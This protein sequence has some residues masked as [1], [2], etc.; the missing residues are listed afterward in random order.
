MVELIDVLRAKSKKDEHYLLKEHIKDT[1]ERAVQIW[2][3]VNKNRERIEYEMLKSEDTFKNLAK[4]LFL[5]DLGKIDYGFQKKVFDPEERKDENEEWQIIKE[6]FTPSEKKYPVD[7]GIRDHEIL[8]VIHTV[9]FKG[10]EEWDKKI[11]TAILLH[12]YNKFFMEREQHITR[13]LD[14]Y[15]QIAG[16][17]YPNYL[18]LMIEK[19]EKFRKIYEDLIEYITQE[20][21]G[22]ENAKFILDAL[23]ELKIDMGKLEELK[24]R[25]ENGVGVS[26]ILPLYEL[27]DKNEKD[28]L[29]FF[30]FLGLLRRC[31]YSAS[32]GPE[33]SAE[34]PYSIMEE[35]MADLPEK[36]KNKLKLD[37]MWQEEIIENYKDKE[38]IILIAPTGSGKTEFALLWA[39][40]KGKKLLYTLPLRV[41]LNDLFLR[42][43]GEDGYFKKEYVDLLHSTAFIEYLKGESRGEDISIGAKLKEI[44]LFASPILLTTPDQ[45]FLASLKYYGFDK[46]LSLYPS[47]TVVVD[48]IQAYDPEMA[49]I[50][51]KTL[52]MIKEVKGN[53]LIITATFPPYFEKFLVSGE[54]IKLEKVDLQSE[55]S[56]I[57][58]PIKNYDLRRHRV[59]IMDG[60]FVV[61]RK[62]ENK[63]EYVIVKEKLKEIIEKEHPNQNVLIIV[64]NVLKAIEVFR[65]LES[66]YAH[67]KL[68]HSRLMEKE[69]ESRIHEIKDFLNKKRKG[70]IPE[71]ERIIVVS[72][73]I[74]EASVDFDFDVLITEISPIDSQIQRWGRVHRNKNEGEN[75]DGKTPNI[76]IFSSID[77]GTKAIYHPKEVLERTLEVLQ[78]EVN[79]ESVLSYEEERR[80][81]EKVYTTP[82][83][84]EL[85]ENEIRKTLEW[86][87][88]YQASKK[89]E[90]QRIFRRLAGAQLVIPQL[91][92]E[93][94][95]CEEIRELGKI[96]KSGAYYERWMDVAKDVFGE[97]VNS[98]D[99]L[100]VL[101]WMYEYS[102]PVPEYALHGYLKG[103]TQEFL[104]FHIL[105]I[106]EDAK[107]SDI[108]KYGIDIL[109]EDGTDL[110]EW[111][112]NRSQILG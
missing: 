21:E 99:K 46:L 28:T 7:F 6:F 107:V 84:R 13:I 89:S 102:I 86:L 36:I 42:F 53:I 41:A 20:F 16:E 79:E 47:S 31:D 75:Y 14:D 68:L 90:A 110:D 87:K 10:E 70:E 52:Q 56:R 73:Q 33:V 39:R 77:D 8:S 4:A 106:K 27:Y 83:I 49:A 64:N 48:E 109:R 50:I 96:I 9:V 94:G 34:K 61:E 66:D 80:L 97:D 103:Y 100:R 29:D 104:G 38:D 88:F 26:Q 44:R 95:E 74:V 35:I 18:S 17:D 72:T 76:Y 81:I 24:R 57:S 92:I 82:Q 15:P 69:K 67:V 1:L 101:Q 23:D 105:N 93:Y 43:S 40:E 19:K 37:K 5:H 3:F 22:Q 59:K 91:M 60:S 32:A 108:Q 111:L 65:A 11:R 30:V 98:E 112:E 51:I 2:E 55:R 45:I 71:N 62:E 12:H 63:K 25:I 54:I 85:Y 78:E 58:Q